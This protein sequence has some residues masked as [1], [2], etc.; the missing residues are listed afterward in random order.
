MSLLLI[1]HGAPQASTLLLLQLLPAVQIKLQQR[2]H[3]TDNTQLYR[4]SAAGN[5]S[6]LTFLNILRHVNYLK[7]NEDEIEIIVIDI[8]FLKDTIT[9]AAQTQSE[10]CLA[11]MFTWGGKLTGINQ[12]AGVKPL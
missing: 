11:K 6:P 12:D 10:S 5:L 8:V 2:T 1:Q 9:S 3:S 4:S 7:L